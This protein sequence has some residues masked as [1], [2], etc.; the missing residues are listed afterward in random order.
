[1]TEYEKY[2]VGCLLHDDPEATT[3]IFSEVTEADF[4][5]RSAKAIFCAVR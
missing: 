1:M 5:D 2:I 3:D 4:S